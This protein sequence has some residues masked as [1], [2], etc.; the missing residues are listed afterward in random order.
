MQQASQEVQSHVINAAGLKK[1]ASAQLVVKP[2]MTV[3]NPTISHLFVA[4]ESAEL[5]HP[6]RSAV[7]ELT[8]DDE[9]D[10][11]TY[12]NSD[13]SADILDDSQLVTLRLES[14]NCLRFQPD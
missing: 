8:D 7:E 12:V 13:V 9:S 10:A 6:R 1:S 3:A 2:V 11:D 14:G 4:V 5:V